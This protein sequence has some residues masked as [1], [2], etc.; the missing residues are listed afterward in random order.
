MSGLST[1][2]TAVLF[3][4]AIF[5]GSAFLFSGAPV[6]EAPQ[7]VLGPGESL[8]GGSPSV[9]GAGRWILTGYGCL[10]AEVPESLQA[11]NR[12][13]RDGK[14]KTE[15]LFFEDRALM[16]RE[17]EQSGASCQ[18]ARA[19]RVRFSLEG[20]M[21]MEPFLPG[22]SWASSSR[23]CHFGEDPMES[24]E[25]RFRMKG[26][27]AFDVLV[28][29]A[30]DGPPPCAQGEMVVSYRKSDPDGAFAPLRRELRGKSSLICGENGPG[31]LE[32]LPGGRAGFR[33]RYQVLPAGADHREEGR[34]DERSFYERIGAVFLVPVKEDLLI[35]EPD[36]M[37]V[38]RLGEDCRSGRK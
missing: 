4:V 2:V 31:R 34:L 8:D 5:A 21:T 27:G 26:A 22:T 9:P 35:L 33:L 16:L 13:V 29:R 36:G 7:V 6:T 10:N 14:E 23:G 20:T 18:W 38:F 1:Q 28:A 24:R 3:F 19:D 12:R 25:L 15:V 37:A 11:A 30:T 17:F 32:V